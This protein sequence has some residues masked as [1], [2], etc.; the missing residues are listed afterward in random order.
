MVGNHEKPQ[1]I[2]NQM[3]N[4]FTPACQTLRYLVDKSEVRLSW[5]FLFAQK[6]IRLFHLIAGENKDK[7]Y[8]TLTDVKHVLTITVGTIFEI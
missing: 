4:L 7:T 6:H 1:Q 5:S 3:Q 8:N 2:I